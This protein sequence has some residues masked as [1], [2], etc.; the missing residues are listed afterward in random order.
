MKAILPFCVA[1]IWALPTSVRCVEEEKE[2][3]DPAAPAIETEGPAQLLERGRAAFSANDFAVAEEALEKFITDYGEAEEAKEAVRVHR[4]MLAISKVGLKKFAEALEWIDLS[5]KDPELDRR[6]ADELKFWRG[7]CLMT[8]GELV[9]AQ[10]AFGAYWANES[11]QAFKRYEALLLFATL[12]L[13][14]DFPIVAADFLEDQ[15]PKIREPAPEAASRAVVLELYARLQAGQPDKALAVIRREYDSMESMTQV[16]SFQSLALQLGATFLENENW[17]DA[18]TCMQRIWPAEKLI[19]AQGNRVREIEER[20]ALLEKRENTQG[21]VFQLKA[22]LKRVER[23]LANFQKME[24]FDSA[25]QLRLAMAYKGLGRYREAALIMEEMLK[26]MPPDPVVES[27]TLAQLQCW[28]EIKRWPK[29]VA[30]AEQYEKVFGAE[31]K[32][33]PTVLF[34]KAEALREDQ[35]YGTAQLAY[36]DLVERFPEDDFAAKAL[37]MQG[38]LYL[39]QDDNE[40]AL[41]QFDQVQ[42]NYP[43]SG[44]A[45]DADYWTGQAYSFS[46]M[47]AEAR[48]HLEGYLT[49]YETAK[50]LKEAIFRIAV[51]TFSLAEYEEAIRLLE[52]FVD[53]YAG[54]PLTDETNLLLGDAYFGQGDMDAGFAAY[55]RV[56]PS[57]VRF[58]EEAWF[59]K[60]KAYK[61]LEEYETMRSHFERFVAEYPDSNRMPEAVY[62]VGWTYLNADE[63]DKAR[64]IYWDVIEKYGNDPERYGVL[65]V[66]AALP[67]V[68]KDEGE[69]GK[70]EVLTKLQVMKTRATLAKEATRA[71]RAG[72]GK[73]LIV[74]KT[75]TVVGSDIAVRS[76]LLDIFKWV[77]PQNQNPAISVAIAE[78]QLAAGNLTTAK[79]LFIEIRRWHPRAVQR[80]RIYRALGSIAAAEGDREKAIEFY[81]KFEREALA[82]AQLGEVRIEKAG[83]LREMGK[84]RQA[85]ETLES[86]LETGGVTAQTKAGALFDLGRTC[87]EAG[88]LKR[89]IVYFERLYVAYGKFS[90]LNAKAYWE[91]ANALENLD[92]NREA[93]ETYEELVGRADLARFDETK[94]AP[95]KIARLKTLVPEVAPPEVEKEEV[96]L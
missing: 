71:V 23:E 8:G 57:A 44:M 62:W 95:E 16:I 58:F 18:I 53:D 82:S 9:D 42:R 1:A 55:E 48:E 77:D 38:F 78:A 87:V 43:E 39:Q 12:Y 22:I 11:H 41:Y 27:A 83:I 4:P 70:E 66:I 45:Q 79:N 13:Q 49:R 5:L 80:D 92:L 2:N 26:V 56:R 74:G 15:Q 52:G 14:Q 60:G 72:Y 86:V 84:T 17:Y 96:T 61:L 93:L 7:I 29:A 10:H 40:G 51:C 31:A 19:E 24:N 65:D 35:Q 37:F 50:Y 46:G 73:S 21:V 59:K 89:A 28:M 36:G 34:L 67:K 94:M 54:D 32:F 68:Y 6:L 88:D 63:P 20:I 30:A 3:A 33:L 25:L 91:R 76:E 69:A 90:E 85:L 75:E 47:Y 81:D 64:E